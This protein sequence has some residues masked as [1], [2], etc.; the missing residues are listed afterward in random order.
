MMLDWLVLEMVM[1]KWYKFLVKFLFLVCEL[2][3][4]VKIVLVNELCCLELVILV[5]VSVN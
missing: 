5:V 3:G 1:V 2:N 4:K